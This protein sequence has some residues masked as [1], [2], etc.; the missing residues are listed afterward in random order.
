MS[1]NGTLNRIYAFDILKF[2]G[3]IGI[4]LLHYDWHLI[5]Q[6]FLLVE[7]FFMMSGFCLY[8]N[9]NNYMSSNLKMLLVKRLKSFYILYII[10]LFG[11]M[12]VTE[13]LFSLANF[14]NAI[15][16]L[17]SI[18]LAKRYAYGA[19]WFLGVWLFCYLFYV[20]LF[21]VCSKKISV[22]I[23]FVIV[24]MGLCSIYTYSPGHNLNL[25]DQINIGP[26]QFGL[27][28]GFVGIGFG[29]LLSYFIEHMPKTNSYL[30][31][32]V[33]GVSLIL[34][35]TYLCASAS[36][37]YDLLN[38]I[39]V[40]LIISCI[41]LSTNQCIHFMN[42][43]GERFKN[44]FSL[45]LAIYIFHPIVIHALKR[46]LQNYPLP[47]FLHFGSSYRCCDYKANTRF[48]SFIYK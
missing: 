36:S 40:A 30:T 43:L 18:G 16:F 10:A 4:A 7:M 48:M 12:I 38:Y 22:L 8:L 24:F 44:V 14:L 39:V 26:F 29:I 13:R 33:M 47:A 35:L 45:S 1:V 41:Y 2:F 32:L 31:V 9:I 19:W 11:Q 28:R 27:I 15:F 6:G 20:N 5:P 25:V 34:L 21:R 3:A 46:V 23:I 37:A 17:D 42:I